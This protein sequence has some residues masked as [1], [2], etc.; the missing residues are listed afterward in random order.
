MTIYRRLKGRDP[1]SIFTRNTPSRR[2]LFDF[3]LSNF[4]ELYPSLKNGY[5]PKVKVDEYESHYLISF[6]VPG[7]KEDEIKIDI[8]E[9]SVNLKT[10]SVIKGY[11]KTVPFKHPINTKNVKAYSVS[12]TYKIIAVKLV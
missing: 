5:K 12:D 9:N 8:S 1:Y 6:R 2:N 3:S 11:S 10:D 4:H 7:L